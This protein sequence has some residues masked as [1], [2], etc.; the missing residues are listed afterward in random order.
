MTDR[1]PT[2]RSASS[3][4]DSSGLSRRQVIIATATASVGIGA[5]GIAYAQQSQG[6]QFTFDARITG[7][8]APDGTQNP[9]LSL[10]AG[11]QY[12]VQW[13]N[14]D[15]APHDF[16]IRDANGNP[17]LQSPTLREQGATQTVEFTAS[18]EM[19]TYICSFHPTTMVGDIQV[20]GGAGGGNQ[21]DQQQP[22]GNQT[23]QQ[24]PKDDPSDDSGG[25]LMADEACQ[26]DDNST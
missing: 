8:I 5:G 15:G 26:K 17:I 23:D 22:T 9:T 11:T 3:N 1:S 20:S 10:E 16:D 14:A 21:T 2:P 6:Q 18:E 25:P 13:T 7:W 4:D 12:T 19:A 24:L